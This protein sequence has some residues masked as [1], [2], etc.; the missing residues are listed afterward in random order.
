[1]KLFSIHRT[2]VDT[3]VEKLFAFNFQYP[4]GIKSTDTI[5]NIITRTRVTRLVYEKRC[6]EV[7]IM[8]FHDSES[9]SNKNR[10]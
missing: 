8:I 9:E 7:F 3:K 10:Y 6:E 1:M 5:N 4:K 2:C